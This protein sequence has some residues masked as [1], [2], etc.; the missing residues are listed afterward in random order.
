MSNSMNFP[1]EQNQDHAKFSYATIPYYI[2]DDEEI[3]DGAKLLYARISNMAQEG[4][5]WAGNKFLAEK[6][7]VCERTIQKWLKQ[8]SDAEYIIVEIEKGTFNTR[9]NIWLSQEFKKQF[10]KR[11]TVRHPPNYSSPP[12]ELQFVHNNSTKQDLEKKLLLEPKPKETPPSPT[13]PKKVSSSSKEVIEK[14]ASP[15][16]KP[17]IYKSLE[18]ENFTIEEK[19][20]LTQHFSEDQIQKALAFTN[21]QKS[22]KT[23]KFG[24][25]YWACKQPNLPEPV[26]SMVEKNR[27]IAADAEKALAGKIPGLIIN[28]GSNALEFAPIGSCQ[29]IYLSYALQNFKEQ[30]IE[31][32]KRWTKPKGAKL[33]PI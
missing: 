25:L 30:V 21:S 33:C 2:L 10:T 7:K 27:K 1:Q 32:L 16:L 28:A 18:P 20:R 15:P 5:C 8:L 24:C 19:I 14:K 6:H 4:R 22:Y 12:P 29:P 31:F 13:I 17:K 23:N 9:R 11:T 3:E 26:E